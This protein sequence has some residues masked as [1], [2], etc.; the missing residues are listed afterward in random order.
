[1]NAPD[2]WAEGVRFP[3]IKIFEKGEKRRDVE[4]M[5]AANNRTPTFLGDLRAQVGAA[6][7][8]VRRLQEIVERFGTAQVRAAVRDI[9]AYAKRRFRDEV[10]AWP[11]GVYESDVYVDHDP[12]GK[13]DIHVHCKVTVQGADLTVDFTGSD[14]RPDIQAYSTYG[15][16]RG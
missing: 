1:V 15:N 8:G 2:I 16:T 3:V 5:L 4:Y 7:L 6:Q 9:I 13:E 11:D 12:H 14:D 10:A